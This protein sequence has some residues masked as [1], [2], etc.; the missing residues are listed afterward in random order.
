MFEVGDGEKEEQ[1]KENSH[2]NDG[3]M[4]SNRSVWMHCQ[5]QEWWDW[6]V[7]A[8]TERE[9][10]LN[11]R[12]SRNTFHITPFHITL[13]PHIKAFKARHA[14]TCKETYLPEEVSRNGIVLIATESGYCTLA[15]LFSITKSSVC[16][17]VHVHLQNCASCP[18]ARLY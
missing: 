7:P 17:I 12:M 6:D 14:E 15:N 9:L 4:W 10:F 5:S 3:F 2:F 13:V 18:H 1:E 16:L 11:S 8:F